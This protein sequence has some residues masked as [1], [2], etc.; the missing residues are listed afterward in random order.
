MR[1]GN[2]ILRCWP[3]PY[4]ASSWQGVQVSPL[5]E[6]FEV[7]SGHVTMNL[8]KASSKRPLAQERNALIPDAAIAIGVVLGSLL[9]STS[10][11]YFAFLLHRAQRHVDLSCRSIS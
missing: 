7:L 9:S 3:N 1:F 8:T 6:V 11:H 5:K 10:E 4:K 2:E